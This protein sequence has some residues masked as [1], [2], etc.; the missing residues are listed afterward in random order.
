[1]HTSKMY[2]VVMQVPIYVQG[3]ETLVTTEWKRSLL[4]LRDSLEGKLGELTLFA[5]RLPAEHGP[6]Q[7][8][9]E[10]LGR[11]EGVRLVPS[12]DGRSHALEYWK[13]ERRRFAEELAPFIPKAR[14]V[15]SGLDDVWRPIAFG[16]YMKCVKAGVPTV[17]VQ[18]TDI[19]RQQRELGARLHGAERMKA[20]VYSRLYE[21]LCRWGVSHASLCLLKGRALMDRYAR[22]AKNVKCFHNTSHSLHDV[23]PPEVV[24][25]RFRDRIDGSGF[26]LRLVYCG[27]LLMRKGLDH[28]VRVIAEARRLG[29]SVELDLIGDGPE[30]AEIAALVESLGLSQVV[31]FLGTRPYG[32]PLIKEL[33][34]YDALLFTPIAEDTP[35]M[36]FDGY[37]AGL[38]VLGYSIPY[39]E[40]C[41][42]EDRAGVLLPLQNPQESGRL[43]SELAKQP[44][45]MLQLGFSALQAGRRHA[46]EGWYRQRA[47]W[48]FEMLERVGRRSASPL[49]MPV[50]SGRS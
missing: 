2:L 30:R 4:L 23:L 24:R 29:A 8:R 41:V 11:S 32:K 49:V 44:E 18:D 40:E 27:R 28:S 10:K 5:P 45:R 22:F 26:T 17:F 25:E 6:R 34:K 36:I 7:Q 43:I 37:A 50:A 46:C 13:T 12:I 21:R 3:D 42:A 20:E 19:V 14:V 39:V 9:L 16:G 15:H 35:R 38:P 33:G 47:E 1:V 48:T 31:R